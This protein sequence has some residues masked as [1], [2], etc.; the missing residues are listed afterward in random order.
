M[1]KNMCEA[2][3][4]FGGYFSVPARRIVRRLGIILFMV[5]LGSALVQADGPNRVAL[6]VD[7]GGG[8]VTTQCI[9]FSEDKISGLEVLERS[10]LDLNI[11]AGGGMGGSVCRIDNEGCTYPGEDCFCQ[12][13][14]NNSCTF[15]IYWHLINGDWKFSGLGSANYLV[16]DGDVEGWKWGIGS[17]TDGGSATPPDITFSEICTTPATSTPTSTHTP[18][19]TPEPTSTPKPTDTVIH[20]FTADKQVINAGESV[21]LS[22]NLSDAEGAYLRYNGLEEGVVAPGSKTVSPTS[23]T[24]YKLVAR[25]EGGESVSEIIITVNAAVPTPTNTAQAAMP[26]PATLPPTDTAAIPEPVVNFNSGTFTVSTGACTTLFWDVQNVT[27]VYLD[28]TEVDL[29][30]SQ[31]AC[32][33]QTQVYTLWVL[34]PGG[35]R[36]T[37]LTLEVSDA[38][39]PSVATSTPVVSPT[40]T[41]IV[42]S[43]PTPETLVAVLDND[44]LPTAER[45]FRASNQ[46]ESNETDDVA[47]VILYGGGLLVLILFLAIPVVLLLAGSVLWWLRRQT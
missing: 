36:T 18:T 28:D 34:Y 15:W 7:H 32:P 11:D 24:V 30:G 44:P 43:T 5:I 4:N 20:N 29:H 21:V 41:P 46:S 12:C 16:G 35:E 17:P 6:V 40:D 3:H 8:S 26:P 13:Q 14:N 31:Q 42:S 22:W 47:Q 25:N 23:T 9:E 33:T 2:A 19:N 38:I 27:T 45:R 37:Q 39:V 10:G 1:K